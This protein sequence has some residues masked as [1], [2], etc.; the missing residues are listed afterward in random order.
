M[1]SPSVEIMMSDRN[2]NPHSV[3]KYPN[4]RQAAG[5]SAVGGGACLCS[6]CW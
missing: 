6:L 5:L 1:P 3:K 2:Y 4:R